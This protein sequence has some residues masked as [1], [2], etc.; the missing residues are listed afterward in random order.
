MRIL[1]LNTTYTGGGAERVTRQIYDGM[2]ERGHE[3]YEIVCYNRKGRIEDK[4]VHVLYPNTFGKVLQRLQTNNRSNCSLSIPYALWY[5]CHFIKKYEIDVVHL[6]N[7]HDSFLG[8]RDIKKIQKCCPMVWTLHD[9][10]A[11]TGHCAMPYECG[12]QWKKGCFSCDY[13]DSYPRLRKDKSA[14]LFQEKRD[15]FTG[16]GIQYTVPSLWM[17]EQFLQS[18]LSKESCSVVFNSLDM[19]QWKVYHKEELRKSYQIQTEKLILAFVASDL[20][21]PRKGMGI[22]GKALQDLDSDKYFLLVAGAISE[23]FG[24]YLKGFEYRKFGYLSEQEK[25]NEFYALADVLV[26]PSLYETFGLVNIEAMACETP[27]IVFAVGAVSEVIGEKAAWCL[28]EI[29]SK[30][31]QTQLEEVEKN[32]NILEE[33]RKHC[34]NYVEETYSEEQ[35]LKQYEELYWRVKQS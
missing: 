24:V 33:K 34:R 8:I 22:L 9:F 11:L 32:R 17:K 35:M 10:W 7:P 20:N 14:K 6:H 18:Y 31:L 2:K 16:I 19:K 29:T 26:N 30:A 25:M 13:L 23:E 27:V 3:V 28:T 1:Y 15:C 4:N 21:N 12:E 5:I